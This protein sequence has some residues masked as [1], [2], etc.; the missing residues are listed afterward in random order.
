MAR[1]FSTMAARPACYL[2][3]IL[4][5]VFLV[6]T[7]AGLLYYDD[8]LSRD[9]VRYPINSSSRV[10]IGATY[11]E[12]ANRVRE[13]FKSKNGIYPT[14]SELVW[15]NNGIERLWPDEEIER[16]GQWAIVVYII[17]VVLPALCLM[18]MCRALA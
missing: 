7:V 5:A 17:C 4:A 8:L 15:E 1:R 6:G 3:T 14:D 16:R 9:T 2:T 11:T 12:F 10:V 13:D 18:S